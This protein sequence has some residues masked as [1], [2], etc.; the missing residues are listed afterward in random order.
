MRSTSTEDRV[1]HM[2]NRK[3]KTE[4]NYEEDDKKLETK[5]ARKKV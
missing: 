2:I 1:R 4:K 5:S 3:R